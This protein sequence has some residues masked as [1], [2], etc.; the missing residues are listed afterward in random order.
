MAGF[1][2]FS[3]ISEIIDDVSGTV[4]AAFGA[5]QLIEAGNI[6]KR[7]ERP[8]AKIAP[9]V[10]RMT[11][12]L[13]GRTLARDIPGG[14]IARNEIKGAT[15]AGIRAASEMGSGAEAYGML[16][17]LVGGEQDYFSRLAKETLGQRMDY[18]KLFVDAL[19]TKADEENRVD[20]WN[21][22]QPYLQAVERVNA[23]RSAGS[24]NLFGGLQGISGGASSY[25]DYL[26]MSNGSGSGNGSGG[27]TNY[28]FEGGQD[29]FNSWLDDYFKSKEKEGN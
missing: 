27:G 11:N 14:E 15:A 5:S 10:D 9:S 16:G 12:Y 13:Y 22:I 4:Q 25:M 17:T 26:S 6:E 19:K 20:Y 8:T 29:Q 2:V 21:R 24:Q 28:G 1:D 23:L 7:T 18:D 3:L